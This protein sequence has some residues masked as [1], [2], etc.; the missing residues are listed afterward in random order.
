MILQSEPVQEAA[1]QVAETQ[2]DGMN[3]IIQEPVPTIYHRVI[4]YDYFGQE[5][6]WADV[7]DGDFLLEPEYPPY[8]EG[9]VFHYWYDGTDEIRA[10][11]MFGSAVH[12][13]IDLLPYHTMEQPAEAQMPAQGLDGY[14]DDASTQGIQETNDVGAPAQSEQQSFPEQPDM[15]P[16]HILAEGIVA[17]AAAMETVPRVDGV[18]TPDAVQA[19]GELPQQQEEPPLMQG[20]LAEINGLVDAER[21][22]NTADEAG[23][24]ASTPD[25][26]TPPETPPSS[27]TMEELMGEA[28][29]PQLSDELQALIGEESPFLQQILSEMDGEAAEGSDE[30]SVD[31][32]IQETLTQALESESAIGAEQSAQEPGNEPDATSD[33]LMEGAEGESIGPETIRAELIE[34]LESEH[35]LPTQQAAE[36]ATA[37]EDVLEMAEAPEPNADAAPMQ[38]LEATQEQGEQADNGVPDVEESPETAAETPELVQDAGVVVHVLSDEQI[39]PGSRVQLVSEVYGVP[40]GANLRYQWQS[41]EHGVFQDIP[42][43]TGSDY[44]YMVSETSPASNWRVLVGV[45]TM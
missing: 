42:G 28:Q 7:L 12:R 36:E 9:Y 20:L 39:G 23:D 16:S 8:A 43:A 5:Y 44:S 21:A 13:A 29:G 26:V 2:E 25:A 14:W 35:T 32:T 45:D 3:S 1:P 11:Y 40:E 37:A 31:T 34:A 24:A 15:D 18:L 22:Q 27:L 41:D 38:A 19:E 17:D 4:F 10:P 6:A 33:A 30:Q